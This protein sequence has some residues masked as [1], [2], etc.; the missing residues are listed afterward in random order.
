MTENEA[1]EAYY[2]AWSKFVALANAPAFKLELKLAPGEAVVWDNS[3][4]MHGRT[5]YPTGGRRWL[6]G[7]YIDWDE[8]QSTHD[9]W[10]RERREM[11]EQREQRERERW[12]CEESEEEW[13]GACEWVDE[14]PR[15]SYSP[16]SWSNSSSDSLSSSLDVHWLAT[17]RVLAALRTQEAFKYGEGVDMLQHALQ[18]ADIARAKGRAN[19]SSTSLSSNSSGAP[20]GD[21]W[22]SGAESGEVGNESEVESAEAVLAC[23]LH[24]VGNSPQA[25]ALELA[26][27]GV[28]PR[29]M[30]A[31]D[32][33]SVGYEDHAAV[34]ARFCRQ[35]GFAEAVCGAVELHVPAKRAIVTLDPAYRAQLSAASV[36]TLRQ[37]GGDMAPSELEAFLATKGAKEAMRLRRYDDMGKDPRR[38]VPGGLHGFRRLIYKHLRER[39]SAGSEI[40]ADTKGPILS[41]RNTPP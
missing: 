7:A 6:Q 37:Q 9:F 12:A 19:R 1:L 5:A 40:G 35:E 23:L 28:A 2:A 11:Q 17:E 33:G 21:E 4:L 14:S 29:L 31:E 13:D 10:Q 32:D 24:D 8:V 3:R 18:V 25:R 27:R 36:E 39:S 38:L 15:D 22:H 16:A 26:T 34:G 41:A 30:V 20:G